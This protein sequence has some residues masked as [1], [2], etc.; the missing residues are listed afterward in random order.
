MIA[1]YQSQ[2]SLWRSKYQELQKKREKNVNPRAGRAV[3]K[4]ETASRGTRER[5]RCDLHLDREDDELVLVGG[6]GFDSDES[7]VVVN[8]SG[9]EAG[10]HHPLR[11]E[12]GN[13]L[14]RGRAAHV[15]PTQT[16]PEVDAKQNADMNTRRDLPITSQC[17]P[18]DRWGAPSVDLHRWNT[19]QQPRGTQRNIKFMKQIKSDA[20]FSTNGCGHPKLPAAVHCRGCGCV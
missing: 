15:T 19:S 20:S 7:R 4:C 12:R 13:L 5:T 14:E 2:A 8:V 1:V 9:R 16:A 3:L 18:A 6:V 11:L 10:P 17:L